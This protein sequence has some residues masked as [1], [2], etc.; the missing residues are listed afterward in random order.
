[1]S[2]F[3]SLKSLALSYRASSND[4]EHTIGGQE[5]F[6]ILTTV[7]G[8]HMQKIIVT[9]VMTGRPHDI[10]LNLSSSSN[11]LRYK[12][13]DEILSDSGKFPVL[14]EVEFVVEDWANIGATD[15]LRG[16]LPTLFAKGLFKT[17]R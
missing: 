9:I 4:S 15:I 8:K 12:K 10:E 1:M 3:I 13:L 6:E 17:R 14:E 5:V 7:H 2:N 16:A 11:A